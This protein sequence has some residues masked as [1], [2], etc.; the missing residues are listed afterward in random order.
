MRRA[1]RAS[2]YN[3]SR[4]R[5]FRDACLGGR[6]RRGLFP[7]FIW[8]HAVVEAAARRTRPGRRPWPGGRRSFTRALVR[9]VYHA[10]SCTPAFNLGAGQNASMRSELEGS[11]RP[12]RQF[13]REASR[14]LQSTFAA[15]HSARRKEPNAGD[16]FLATD[17]N[18]RLQQLVATRRAKRPRRHR[19]AARTVRLAP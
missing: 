6:A 1:L 17:T 18:C 2:G 3:P 5:F 9:A 19:S 16:Q 4:V 7:S 13:L 15:Y 12:G 10:P 14:L 11:D 8:T